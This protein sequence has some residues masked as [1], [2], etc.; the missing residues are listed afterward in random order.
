MIENLLIVGLGNPGARYSK[1]RHNL[2]ATWVERLCVA[3]KATLT[4][5]LKLRSIISKV[6]A[7]DCICIIP[8]DYMNN[9]GL[10]VKLTAN[11]YKIPIENILVIHD[12]LDLPIGTIRLK[13]H[14][15]HG[16]HNGLRDLIE[17]LGTDKF[18][19]LRI[20]IGHPGNK[21]QV[22][23]YVLTPATPNEQ[24]KLDQ[25]IAESFVVAPEL[26]KLNWERAMQLLHISTNNERM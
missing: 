8:D 1:T 2:G 5:N 25:A 11:F 9:S 14:G 7:L 21:D 13:L 15:G 4:F 6:T 23:D 22:S 26:A 3:H 19:R 10:A 24:L 12:D 17:R 18:K 16:G 20:G